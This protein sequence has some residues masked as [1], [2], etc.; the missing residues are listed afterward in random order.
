MAKRSPHS[1]LLLKLVLL[2]GLLLSLPLQAQTLTPASGPGDPAQYRHLSLDNGMGVLLVS[3][4]RADKAAASLDVLV[5]SGDDPRERPG[6]AHFTEHMLFLGTEAYPDPGEYHAFI[7]DHGGSH[8]AYTAFQDTNYFF[9]VDPQH[10]EAA[11]DRFSSQFLTPTFT[12]ELID[13]ERLAVHSEY[14]AMLR[15]DN[16]RFWSALGGSLNQEHNLTTFTVGNR[17]TLSNDD[18][19]L[20]Q[21]VI[22]FYHQRYSANLMQLAVIGPQSLDTLEAM[23]RPRFEAVENRQ[24][25][26]YAHDVPLFTDESLPQV[27][28]VQSLRDTRRLQLTFPIPSMEADY[29]NKPADY[30]AHLIGH[31]GPGSLHDVLRSAGLVNAVSA[32]RAIDTGEEALFSISFTLTE[33]GLERWKDIASLSF[34]YLQQIASD[35]ITEAY[36]EEMQRIRA[37]DLEFQEQS[38]PISQAST[39]T[40]RMHRVVPEHAVIAPFMMES[41]QPDTYRELLQL[42]TPERM[43]A[44]LLAPF[45]DDDS[46]Q[47]TEW[48]DTPYHIA[49]LDP[50]SVIQR[51]NLETLQA[52]LSLPAPNP[53][54]P[55]DLSLVP[56]AD[57]DHPQ[58]LTESPLTLWYARDTR[59]DAPRATVL[60]SLRSPVAK[61]SPKADVL[62][63]LMLESVE[64]ELSSI[65]YAARV[66]DLDYR[67]Y[68]H[69]RGVTLQLSGYNDK[70]PELMDQILLRLRHPLPSP[71]RFAIHQRQLIDE[72]GNA[73]KRRPQQ[74]ALSRV[75]EVL[76]NDIH[77][78][79]DRLEAAREVT[80]ADL[81][82]H[83]QRFYQALDPVMLV[84]GNVSHAGARGMGRQV[85]ARIM[86]GSEHIDTKRSQVNQLPRHKQ[87]L[88]ATVDHGDT[89]YVRYIQGDSNS[90]E[91]QA[92]YRVLAQIL[93]S[94]FY[95][96]LRTQQQVGYIVHATQYPLL[97]NPAL[98]FIVQSPDHD[99]AEI[100]Q[101]VQQFLEDFT[102]RLEGMTTA[103]FEQQKAAVVTRLS[104]EETQLR[105]IS[106]W[107]WQEIDRSNPAFDT[108]EQM[109]R[110][111]RELEQ[112]ELVTLF[113]Q[114]VLDN[115]RQLVIDASRQ[116]VLEAQGLQQLELEGL[117]D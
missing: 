57:M 107:Y 55:E 5:G 103:E 36:F 43:Q 91:Q 29:A 110:Q 117:L 83:I 79:E 87:L 6:L 14:T 80:L 114:Q 105:A 19:E 12:E 73:L 15:E 45:D 18:N 37:L 42:M 76:V 95:E 41:Y 28:K 51:D 46:W 85:Q 16:R 104:E 26:K 82:S 2:S 97:D 93:S 33:E 108:R 11:L 50:A 96:S 92:Q 65:A 59:F 94:P 9:D 1:M 44:S 24:H 60:L 116:Q 47:K 10:L 86:K 90:F 3:N 52:Q 35:G 58:L 30:L 99:G 39:L 4:P 61:E 63:R 62:T 72:L 78:V 75:P 7:S 84:H 106:D 22:D 34:D 48:Y 98:A 102:A 115:P 74:I 67:L 81:Y 112:K 8:N 71:E 64:D 109:I 89:G 25:D 77:S 54:I 88:A 40:R 68:D 101:R 100:D 70:L 56:G 38:R 21:E 27:L 13:R 53:F 23:V 31:E 17:T 113:K 69:L 66:A 111:V 20:R 32:G 49:S